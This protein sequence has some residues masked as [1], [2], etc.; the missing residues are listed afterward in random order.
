MLAED[1]S[2]KGAG[3]VSA[4]ARRINARNANNGVGSNGNGQQSYP[5]N[6]KATLS[7]CNGRATTSMNGHQN[8]H[9]NGHS[10]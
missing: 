7:K 6:G 5:A 2:G 9:S 10:K 4:I 1:G 8:G 3:L